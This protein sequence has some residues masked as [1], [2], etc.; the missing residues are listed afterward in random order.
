MG[1]PIQKSQDLSSVTSS[2]GLIAGSHVFHRLLTPSHPS[3]ALGGLVTPTR[4]RAA[5]LPARATQSRCMP[6]LIL[7]NFFQSFATALYLE[8]FASSQS[9]PT[10]EDPTHGHIPCVKTA[11][12]ATCPYPIVNEARPRR[13]QSAPCSERVFSLPVAVGLADAERSVVTSP[14]ESS[15][16]HSLP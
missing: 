12:G 10:A 13:N 7:S 9:L 3:C 11:V 14:F 15:L 1:C 4:P 8:S 16:A 6:P 5:S 2:S